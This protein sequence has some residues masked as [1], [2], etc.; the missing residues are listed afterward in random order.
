MNKKIIILLPLLLL[1]LFGGCNSNHTTQV[2]LNDINVT[3]KQG[4]NYIIYT[5]EEPA[6]IFEYIIKDDDGHIMDSGYHNYRGSFDIFEKDNLLVMNYG[7]GGNSWYERYYDTTSGRIS[8]F[9]ERPVASSDELVAYFITDKDNEIT[10]IVQNIFNPNE[11]HK[12][13]RKNFSDYA[14]KNQATAEFTEDNA[15]LKL[16]YWTKPDNQKVTE[17]IDL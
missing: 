3:Y 13:I 17:T 4:D 12:E 1:F 5:N 10:L 7:M 14:I 11:Y 8:R 9:F 6:T 16:T 2:Q 15:K